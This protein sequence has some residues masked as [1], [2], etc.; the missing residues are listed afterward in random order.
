MK[1]EQAVGGHK[2]LLDFVERARKP[3]VIQ[4]AS[5]ER[6]QLLGNIRL[7]VPRDASLCAHLVESHYDKDLGIRSLKN[8]IGL[9]E[10]EVIKTYLNVDER[11]EETNDVTEYTINLDSNEVTV[12]RA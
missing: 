6:M 3:V 2:Y 7:R 5:G 10:N 8:G 12:T 11:I 1:G 9:V 4:P